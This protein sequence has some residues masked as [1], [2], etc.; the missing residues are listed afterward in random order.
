MI[1]IIINFVEYKCSQVFFSSSASKASMV[2]E[3][4]KI[5]TGLTASSHGLF[6]LPEAL[7][8]LRRFYYI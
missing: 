1:L 2:T 5:L 6:E 4:S 8:S 3:F 7:V